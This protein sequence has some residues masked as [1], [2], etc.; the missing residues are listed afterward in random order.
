MP[1]SKWFI[2]EKL[3]YLLKESSAIIELKF[4]FVEFEFNRKSNY[5]VLLETKNIC[6]IKLHIDEAKYIAEKLLGYFNYNLENVIRELT[7]G[8][9]LKL[10]LQFI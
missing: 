3:R 5:A 4:D 7:D 6:K 1:Y 8:W 2:E 9:S 10:D